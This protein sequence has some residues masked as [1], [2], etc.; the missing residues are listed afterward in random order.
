MIQMNC[1]IIDDDEL[2][3]VL[4]STN[5]KK[6]KYLT[7]K[8]QF[9][10]APDAIK[11]LKKHP[12]IDLIF[13]DIEMPEMSGIGFLQ[14]LANLPQVI[15]TSSKTNYAL[16]AYEYEVTDYI[17]KPV[18]YARIYK[19]VQRAHD[20]LKKFKQAPDLGDGIFIK[21]SATSF[22]R[23]SYS[24]ILWVEALENYVGIHTYDKKY[25]ILF[26]MKS[27]LSKLPAESFERVHRSFI[28]NLN[29]IEF[30]RDDMIHYQTKDGLK[31]IPITKSYK[32]KLMDKLNTIS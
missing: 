11:Y 5:I 13:L 15:I 25:T 29:K 14:S 27:F 30:I 32:Q 17:T 18:S 22:H 20:N 6:I 4:L 28:A 1:I 24:D 8:K 9:D 3:R 10:N 12:D 23:L 26:T 19:A 16:E 7:L 2:S 21:K 31:S